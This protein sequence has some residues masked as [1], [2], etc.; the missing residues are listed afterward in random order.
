V[1]ILHRGK[2][3]PF[4]GQ[5]EE[6]HCDRND[7]EGIDRALSGRDFDLVFDN[8]YD[9]KRGT[10]AEHVK[11]AALACADSVER[12][13]F[14]SS[15]AAYGSGLGRDEDDPLAPPDFPD[16]YCRNKADSERFLLGIAEDYGFPAVTLRPP[17]V[18]GPE[19]PFH[20]EAFFWDRILADRT[21]VVPGDGSRPMQFVLADDLARAALLAAD[22]DEAEGKAYN[23][24]NPAPVTQKE[25]VEALGRAA[26]RAPRIAYLARQSIEK[27]GGNV[28]QPPLY[29]GQ[30][31][32]VPP[33]TQRTERAAAE[34]G[35]KATPF[36]IGLAATFEWYQGRGDGPEKGF[37]FDDKL[38]AA[39]GVNPDR[40]E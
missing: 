34:L 32:D 17:F 29:F 30:Y 37:E 20:R 7:V 16:T 9:W 39:A 1:T 3:N 22:S 24:A 10:T 33:I 25:L 13:V 35:F 28:F 6:I 2:D 5:A 15:V 11:A 18:Y 8:V 4:Q 27:L 21:V 26:G 40:I 23:I 12:Y 38:L 36:D 31:Y 14:M 19:N